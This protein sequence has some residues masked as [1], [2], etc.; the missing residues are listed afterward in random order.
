MKIILD[1]HIAL[2]LETARGQVNCEFSG[3][4]FVKY[5]KPDF[6]VYDASILHVGSEGY[7]EIKTANILGLLNRPD[8]QAMK[9]WFHAHPVGDGI[10]GPHNWSSTDHNTCRETPLGGI[11]ELVKWAIAIVRTPRGW[12]GRFDSFGAQGRTIHAEVIPSLAQAIT[13]GLQQLKI[14]YAKEMIEKAKKLRS[15]IPYMDDPWAWW[16]DENA[17]FTE[18]AID[19]CLWDPMDYERAVVLDYSDKAIKSRRAKTKEISWLRPPTDKER[20]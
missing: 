10:P 13:P 3:L 7:T 19:E 2:L 20:T 4:G 1:P 14:S 6:Y 17:L 12:V 11:P 16:D 18:D 9:L 15:V 5:Q 8:A